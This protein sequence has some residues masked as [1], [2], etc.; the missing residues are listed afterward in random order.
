MAI[1]VLSI[2]SLASLARRVR[3]RLQDKSL[4]KPFPLCIH[5]YNL[6]NLSHLHHHSPSL[7][8]P[9]T[10]STSNYSPQSPRPTSPH[11]AQ[12]VPPHPPYSPPAHTPPAHPPASSP[13]PAASYSV[14]SATDPPR[15]VYSGNA[16]PDRNAARRSCPS[17]RA[18]RCLLSP[19]LMLSPVYMLMIG[20]RSP[21]RLRLL[22]PALPARGTLQR[23]VPLPPPPAAPRHPPYWRHTHH[24][25][26]NS[27][28]A[29]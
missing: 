5:L 10:A 15:P 16:P 7:I 11:T 24:S 19:V 14:P 4:P 8:P 13:T 21:H 27:A 18:M 20:Q 22:E 23:A 1:V 25:D 6:S 29:P 28:A 3:T 17:G 9:Q 26:R 12:T 2:P